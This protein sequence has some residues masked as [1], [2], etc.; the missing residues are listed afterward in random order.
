[1]MVGR[2]VSFKVEKAAREPGQVI[3]KID[4]LNVK[5]ARKVLALKHF[6]IE[7][8][9]GEILGVAGVEGNGQTELIEALTGLR[10][11]ESGSIW[12]DG[13]DMTQL[14]IR[15]RIQ[16]GMAHIPEDRQ[17][18]WDWCWTT[19]SRR[20]SSSKRIAK[21][22]SRTTVFSTAKRSGSMPS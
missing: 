9:A 11:I 14:S 1:M 18:R 5:N 15:E 17:K 16:N 8:R 21:R 2:Q 22:P 3:L 19:R 6:S 20:T 7:L 12:L 10:K 13:K 4:D